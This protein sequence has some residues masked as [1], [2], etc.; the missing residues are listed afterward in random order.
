MARSRRRVLLAVSGSLGLGAGCLGTDDAPAASTASRTG[1]STA[2]DRGAVIVT[3]STTSARPPMAWERTLTVSTASSTVTET[4]VCGGE[5]TTDS[6]S[7]SASALAPF[8]ALRE[9]DAVESFAS[10]YECSEPCPTDIPPTT[11]TISTPTAE[12]RVTVAA[13][14]ETPSSLDRLLDALDT[15]SQQVSAGDC[16]PA[17]PTVV[18]VEA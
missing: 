10:T 8:R 3:R 1:D 7:L 4:L 16:D 18:T 13:G 12:Q 17:E 9:G 11:V 5:E 2:T 15:A 14:A 6:A